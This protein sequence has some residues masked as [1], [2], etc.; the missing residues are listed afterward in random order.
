[1]VAQWPHP[2]PS[3]E[4]KPGRVTVF[5][6]ELDLPEAHLPALSA[7]M[8]MEERSRAGRLLRD[9]D[10]RRFIAAHGQMRQVLAAHLDRMPDRLCFT[11]NDTGKPYLEGGGLQ[12]NLSHSQSVGL[13]AVAADF[14]VGVDVETIRDTVDFAD[15]ARHFFAPG[16][17]AQLFALPPDQQLRAFFTCWTRKEAY[18]KANGLGLYMPLDA[19]EVSVQPASSPRLHRLPPVEDWQ[20][21]DLPISPQHAA[22]LAVP[23]QVGPPVL[24]SWPPP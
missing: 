20:L 19:F 6:L 16:E 24:Y 8:G 18:M 7:L 13:L 1:M 17:V 15:I 22:A 11:A 4:L 23:P 9:C 14:E 5:R 21:Y 10:R 12:F 3:L 2:P